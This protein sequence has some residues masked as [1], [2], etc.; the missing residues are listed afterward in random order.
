[1]KK[2]F[3][4][5]QKAEFFFG[6]LGLILSIVLTFCQVV[7]RYWLH[8][9]IMWIGD[10][11]LYIFIF[12]IYVAISYGAAIKT[13]I[14]VDILPE[15]LCK[16]SKYKAFAFDMV[17]SLVTIVMVVSMWGPTWRVVK[18]AYKYPEFATLVRWFNM[19]WLVYALGAMTVLTVLHY[20]WHACS[21]VYEM[22]KLRWIET[23][24]G[25]AQE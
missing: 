22:K 7:N 6:A 8:Y 17:K 9:E 20:G 15:F 18:R 1:M 10:A 16:G 11:A 25:E 2:L 19:S 3:S 5:L 4:L 12:T 24:E 23:H 21:D 13:H 14:A